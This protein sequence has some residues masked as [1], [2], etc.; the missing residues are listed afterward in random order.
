[1]STF[2]NVQEWLFLILENSNE[3]IAM[4]RIRN[5]ALGQLS[6]DIEFN[7]LKF[8]FNERP[9]RHTYDK[10]VDWLKTV[11][12]QNTSVV[13]DA[14][15]LYSTGSILLIKKIVSKLTLVNLLWDF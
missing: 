4:A 13:E 1:M 5:M 15:V 8:P 6:M 2:T 3:D 14:D 11:L 12:N 7:K 10:L 9:S